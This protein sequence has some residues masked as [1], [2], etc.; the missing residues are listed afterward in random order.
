[1]NTRALRARLRSVPFEPA[2][3]P[4]FYGWVILGVGTIGIIMSAPG[5]TVGVSV[6]T[7][8]LIESLSLSRSLLSLGYLV[9]TLT[10][11]MILAWAGRLYDRHG[12]RLV[13][14]VASIGLAATLVYLSFS[15][16]ISAAISGAVSFVPPAAI[17]FVVIT[18]GFFLLRFSG[19]GVLT[20]ASRNMVME[21]FE[22]RRGMANAFMG[23]AVAFGFSY[24][25]RIF[26]PLVATSGWE[27][28]WR[29]IALAVLA[30]AVLAAIMFRDTP[31]AHGLVPDGGTVKIKRD[32]HPENVPTESFTAEEAR[33]TYAFWIFSLT[34]FM[35]GLV[36][37]AY[38][39]HVVSIFGDAGIPRSEAVGI[40]LPASL[41]AVSVQFLGS[42]LSDRIKLKYLC[43]TQLLGVMIV[44]GG[45]V[46]LR[47][48][49]PVVVV[50]AGHGLMQGVFGITSS[51]TWPRFFG[52]RHLGAVSGLATALSVAGSA[53]GPYLFSFGRDL[54]GSY[55]APAIVC[56]VVT[57]VLFVGSFSANKPVHPSAGETT[58]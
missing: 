6:F 9:G 39:F 11:A 56:G 8:P 48:G 12:A 25:P 20:L 23:V 44:I 33:R 19:Q 1:M 14:T 45:L 21:W 40:F 30:F 58:R 53:V 38:T 52:R 22:S 10:S 24:A 29:M 51:L 35:S 49:V 57:A 27:S 4:F 36:L 5:Q 41:V 43:A 50:V 7:D 46:V 2:R 34:L 54:T 13:A 42:W 47:P 18:L 26:E 3:F 15:A 37:T 17:A 28:A 55:A 16:E 32:P 31:E